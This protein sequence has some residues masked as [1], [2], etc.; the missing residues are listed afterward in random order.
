MIGNENELLTHLDKCSKLL[1]VPI[2]RVNPRR[3]S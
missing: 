3:D 1:L 2:E